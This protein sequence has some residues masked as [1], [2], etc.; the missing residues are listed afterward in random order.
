MHNTE[1]SLAQLIGEVSHLQ[2]LLSWVV[3]GATV[4]DLAILIRLLVPSNGRHLPSAC[5]AVISLTGLCILMGRRIRIGIRLLEARIKVLL[6]VRERPGRMP[7]A[8]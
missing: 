1:P 2:K 8:P 4:G 6:V 3:A 7:E 5:A